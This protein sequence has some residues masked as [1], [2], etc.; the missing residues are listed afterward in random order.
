MFEGTMKNMAS[1]IMTHADSDTM[2]TDMGDRPLVTSMRGGWLDRVC[3]S[4]FRK[5]LMRELEPLQNYSKE[6]EILEFEQDGGYMIQKNVKEASIM[7]DQ[8]PQDCYPYE[9]PA[10]D[11]TYTCMHKKEPEVKE[12]DLDEVREY[13]QEHPDEIIHITV[14]KDNDE[15]SQNQTG[16]K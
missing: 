14:G 15:R 10:E 4:E 13:I 7:P 1:F 5:E 16:V 9:I 2:I 6:P 3:N 11:R 8:F 12:M